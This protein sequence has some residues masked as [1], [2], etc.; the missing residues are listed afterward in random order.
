MSRLL[1]RHKYSVTKQM[2]IGR[3]DILQK[4][5]NGGD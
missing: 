4:A 2:D 3:E 5:T 1:E